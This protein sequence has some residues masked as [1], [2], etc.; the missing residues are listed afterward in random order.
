MIALLW[1]G[2]LVIRII[3][4]LLAWVVLAV[5]GALFMGRA[6]MIRDKNE[7]PAHTKQSGYQEWRNKW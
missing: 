7:K 2:E 1:I 3:P 6:I 4:L 5:F